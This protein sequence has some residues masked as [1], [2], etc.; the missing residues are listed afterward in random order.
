[1]YAYGPVPSR[2]FGR[3]LGVSPIPEKTCSYSCVYCQLGRTKNLTPMR[4]SFFDK[5]VIFSD[6]EKVARANKGNIDYI[7]FVGDG[8]PTLSID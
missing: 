1:M 5:D 8:E 3:S 7:T 4:Q 2:R 6:I